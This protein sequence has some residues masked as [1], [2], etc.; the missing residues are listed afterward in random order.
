[1]VDNIFV[2]ENVIQMLG[3]KCS[4]MYLTLYNINIHVE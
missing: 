2:N 4:Y 3:E 1:M